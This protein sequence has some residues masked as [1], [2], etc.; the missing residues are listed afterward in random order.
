MR[1]FDQLTAPENKLFKH[2]EGCD[3]LKKAKKSAEIETSKSAHVKGIQ[4]SRFIQID[5]DYE[6]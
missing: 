1:K 4:N 3:H 2:N 5:D 6:T